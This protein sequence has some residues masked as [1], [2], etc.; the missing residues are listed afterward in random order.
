MSDSPPAPIRRDTALRRATDAV[1]SALALVVLSPLL[2]LVAAAIKLDSRGPVFFSQVRVG[3]GERPFR[4]LKFRSMVVDA[5]RLGARVSGHRDPRVT[6]VGRVLR[7]TKVDEFPQ[8]W[9]VLVGEMSLVGPRAEVPELVAHFT[10]EE[11]LTLLVRPGLTCAGPIHFTL[12]QAGE[13]DGVDD[14]ETHYLENQLHEKLALDLDYLR[15]RGLVLDLV[16]IG[17]TVRV[18]GRSLGH[19]GSDDR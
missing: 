4:I 11:R 9:N 7:A 19:A 17:R 13:L 1:V 5:S 14:P 15:R 2:G 3:S 6:R 16:L 8:L 10:P 12:A 18:L